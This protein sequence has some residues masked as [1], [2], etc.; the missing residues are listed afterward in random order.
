M[1]LPAGPV[2]ES[3]QIYLDQFDSD[4]AGTLTKLE[5]HVSKRSSGA[6]G[7]YILAVLSRKAGRSKDAIKY[8]LSAKIM[9]PGSEFFR[10]LPYYMQHPDYFDAWV[11]ET[12]PPSNGKSK[13]KPRSTHPI[14][15][16]DQLI[17]KLSKAETKRIQIP[18]SGTDP[19]QSV[20][21]L[22]QRSA[23]VDDIV[24]ETLALIHEKQGNYQAAIH[25][26][27]QLRQSNSSKRAHYDKQILR[28]QELMAND[29]SD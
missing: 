25:V 26:F 24:T 23:D 22:S 4:P 14:R 11:P 18:N 10:R 19:D 3:Y 20:E 29:T 15:D 2:P 16:L 17:S 7:Y 6:V 13:Q 12:A 5:T 21:D 1:E 9:A 8:A 27:K 28:L